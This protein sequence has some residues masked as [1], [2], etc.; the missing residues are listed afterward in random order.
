LRT[1]PSIHLRSVAISIMT[2][3]ERVAREQGVYPD[4]G[5]GW[6]IPFQIWYGKKSLEG[7]LLA[8]QLRHIMGLPGTFLVFWDLIFRGVI[9]YTKDGW[10]MVGQDPDLVYALAEW[11]VLYY[12]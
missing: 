3:E 11:I 10:V 4:S 9:N 12:Q 5:Q 2:L 6:D 8:N 7:F 1:W